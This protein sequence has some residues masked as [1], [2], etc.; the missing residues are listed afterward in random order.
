MG[1]KKKSVAVAIAETK[2]EDQPPPEKVKPKKEPIPVFVFDVIV[3]HLEAKNTEFTNPS[4]LE[5]TA[6]FFKTPLL[7]TNSQINVSDF[8]ANAGLSLQKDPKEIR[9][10]VN[11]CGI[12]FSVVYSKKVIGSGQASFPSSVVD[13]IE[14]DMTDILHSD[15]IDLAAGGE[16]TGK[17]EFLCRLVVMCIAD[18]P[19]LECAR[20]MDRSINAQ[21]IMFVM[22]ESQVC[23]SACEPCQN[24][25]EAEEGDER[26]RL[27]LERY[28]SQ[29]GGIKPYN[30]MTNNASG[31]PACCELK[32]MAIEYE[33]MIDSIT[34]Q[35]GMPPP[36]PPCRSP[37]EANNFGMNPCWCQP[38]L[39]QFLELPEKPDKPCF[40][41]L[42]ATQDHEPDFCEKNLM[43][44][45]I[46]DCDGQ[47]PEIKPIRFCPVCL[48]N[49]SWLPKFAACPKCGIKPMPV[50]EDRH[51]EKK[52]SA[53]Q[54][55]LEYLGK[56]P[57]TV[58]DYCTDPCEKAKKDRADDDECPPCRCSCKFG[59]MCAHCRI[60][61]MCADIFKS[62]QVTPKCPKVEPKESEDYCVVNKSSEDC[63]PYLAKV[64]SELR[65]L[66]DI[67]DTKKLSELDENCDRAV[68]KTEKPEK[69]E[70][71]KEN[72]APKKPPYIPPNN[73]GHISSRHKR[74]VLRSGFVSRQHGWAWS[75]SWEA[76]KLGWRPGAIRKPIKKLMKFFL[77]QPAR[78][79]AF[80]KC[81]DTETLEREKELASPVLNI[82]KKNGEI[83]ITLRPLSPLG[84]RQKPITFRIVKS[85]MAVALRE[86]KRKLKDKGFRKCTCHQTLMMCRCRDPTEKVHLQRALNR[87]CRRHCIP[88]AGDHLVLTDTSESDMEFDF[89][90][91]PPAGTEQPCQPPLPDT[92]NH[93][94]Q[95]SKKDQMPLPPK[96]PIRI[97]PYYRGFDCAVG[98]R[99]MGTAFGWPGEM[100]F[101]DGVF[102]MMGGGPH[103]PNPMPCGRP[104][105]PGAWG[106]GAGG[107]GGGIGG[108]GGARGVLGGGRSARGGGAGGGGFRGPGGPGGGPGGGA[109]KGFPTAAV[110]KAQGQG[111]GKGEKSE[112]IPVR[113]PKRFLKPAEEAAKAAKEAE[114]AAVDAKKKGINMIKYLQKK[115]TLVRPWNPQEGKD[116]RPRPPKGGF[117]GDDGLKDNERKR[118]ML[119]AVP[120][121]PITEMPRRGKA[122]N[123]C[124]PYRM[125]IIY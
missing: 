72:Q 43:P 65:D 105:V 117:V 28:R 116:K 63:R 61:K 40:V 95:T 34:K 54:I 107:D 113:Y 70:P 13:S 111:K 123:P 103:G 45:P 60:R 98:D 46:A 90:V 66:Y 120:P 109:W 110:G 17:L 19:E 88:P 115:G 47:K 35:T 41:Y 23:P 22:G 31:I 78:E 5:V 53:D 67:K 85:E 59:K 52:V 57:S 7:L 26:L 73:K 81:K 100:V 87:E 119:L 99:Y 124:D 68:P 69:Q 101:E 10:T 25:L 49:M 84:M 1:P 15:V 55:L 121:I 108:G 29:G 114:K 20:N 30:M 96:Y 33:R 74:C 76:K 42:P 71:K 122:P 27:D 106:V 12:S 118:K 4:K 38:E 11:D 32:K 24:D 48:T 92:V 79:N 9:K 86:I 80:A 50:V 82:C 44:V 62:D 6:N 58:D 125:D 51:K 18:E 75:N 56:G 16:V 14:K 102:G 83:F 21:D 77:E 104:R 8:K 39:P 91:T 97:P 3:T 112:P 37:D 89:D 36:K 64:F 93:G 94:T 2:P